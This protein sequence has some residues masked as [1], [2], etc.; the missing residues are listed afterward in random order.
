MAVKSCD[1]AKNFDPAVGSR[2]G[3]AV[4]ENLSGILPAIVGSR[5][6]V[7]VVEMLPLLALFV[8]LFGLTFGFW[9]SIHTGILQSIAA[10]HYAFEVINNRTHFLYHRDTK[11]P[12]DQEEYY[13]KNGHRFFAIVESQP[14]SSLKLQPRLGE[15]SLF[16]NDPMSIDQGRDDNR[17]NPI[18][19]KVGY[20]IC[21]DCDCGD[22]GPPC[23][24]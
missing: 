12:S 13:K 7:A 24:P 5:R 15:L 19:L 20:G 11:K 22:I 1:R 17:A 21:M 14:L 16:N 2:G 9:A 4:E 6:G 8:V 18:W 23:S 3:V 10:R